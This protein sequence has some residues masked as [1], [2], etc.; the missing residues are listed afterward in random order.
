MPILISYMN[1]ALPLANTTVLCKNRFISRLASL[2]NMRRECLVTEHPRPPSPFLFLITYIMQRQRV[3]AWLILS[4]CHSLPYDGRGLQPKE[5]A[6]NPCLHCSICLSV[7]ILNL[8][9]VTNILLGWKLCAWNTFF[10]PGTSSPPVYLVDI[11]SHEVATHL[12][13]AS[14]SFHPLL[15]QPIWRNHFQLWTFEG[16]SKSCVWM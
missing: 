16:S 14:L 12:L 2:K 7:G 8:C 10:W 6:G 1:K 15:L 13:H 11:N 5:W 3:K 9:E 4:W